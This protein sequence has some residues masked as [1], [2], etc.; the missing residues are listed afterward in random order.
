MRGVFLVGTLNTRGDIAVSIV[1]LINLLHAIHRLFRVAH[2]FIDEPQIVD[3]ILLYGIHRNEFSNRI[4]EGFSREVEHAPCGEAATEKAHG[5]G[6]H[7]GVLPGFLE[8]R[9]GVLP[10]LMIGEKFAEFEAELKV[11]GILLHSC[12]GKLKSEF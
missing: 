5:L 4:G 11:C 7:I 3:H 1:D 9:N 8:F 6:A 10:T 12:A 2:L